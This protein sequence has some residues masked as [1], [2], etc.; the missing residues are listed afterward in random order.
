MTLNEFLQVLMGAGFFLVHSHYLSDRGIY[1]LAMPSLHDQPELV[2]DLLT[3]CLRSFDTS[4][5]PT[6]PGR[7]DKN[8]NAL[9]PGL[10][11]HFNAWGEDAMQQLEEFRRK[12]RNWDPEGLDRE[13]SKK[14][15]LDQDYK[16]KPSPSSRRGTFEAESD[17][18]P[19][20]GFSSAPRGWTESEGVAVASPCRY[21]LLL[22]L[23]QDFFWTGDVMP[24][25][26][27]EVDISMLANRLR[28]VADG[29]AS[30]LQRCK[31]HL[32]GIFA[33]RQPSQ[34]SHQGAAASS[35]VAPPASPGMR[36][37]SAMTS[38]GSHPRREDQPAHQPNANRAAFP[39]ETVA[40]YMAHIHS[41]Q[42]EVN[43]I[44]MGIYK[45]AEA[46]ITEGP[47]QRK[48]LRFQNY[49]PEPDE[50]GVVRP[51]KREAGQKGGD[52]DELIQFCYQIASEHALR[53]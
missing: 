36:R 44:N 31:D 40:E 46:I 5:T 6:E 16:P 15:R 8:G 14:D 28:L 35:L 17:A 9:Y 10:D 20:E 4:S 49:D 18:E 30:E 43:K 3:K 12:Q 2:L 50:H 21:V 51:R 13:K 7:T 34:Q 41:V 53:S 29:S 39:L 1:V 24:L 27:P 11:A 32:Y 48:R 42:K 19:P 45:L 22:S 23:R 38:S 37:S 25:H 52:V 33:A 26:M 47:K